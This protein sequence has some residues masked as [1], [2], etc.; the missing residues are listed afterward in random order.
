MRLSSV[1]SLKLELSAASILPKAFASAMGL[2]RVSTRLTARASTAHVRQP[3]TEVA[4]GITKGKRRGD[5][6]LSARIQKSRGAAALAESI[7]QS[8]GGECDIRII[9]KVESRAT[10][11]SAWF[12]K[13]QRPLEAGLSCGVLV[14]GRKFSGTLGFIV[15]DDDA[16][17][18]LSNNHVL[19]NVNESEP[20]DPVAQPGT[21]DRKPGEA[22]LIGVLDRYVPISFKR[23][24]VV[25]C[26]IAE[27]FPDLD[28]Y[29]GWTEALPGYVTGIDPITTDDLEKPV[30]KAGRTTGVTRGRITAVE[31]DRLIVDM[32][33]N[34]EA[35]FSDQIEIVGDDNQPFSLGGDSGSLIVDTRGKAVA[36]LFAGGPDLDG[37]DITFANRIESVLAKLGVSLVLN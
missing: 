2:A 14:K 35:Q 21:R 1:Q 5:Y 25:D 22:T 10:P 11:T 20:G 30:V 26:A 15:E 13:K 23:S 9:P 8:S 17:Y 32:G 31:V 19:A 37:I 4:L 33:N 29:A 12:R 6:V 36:L 16:Y 28:F 18:A 24:N 27:I 7:R 34:K 3:S